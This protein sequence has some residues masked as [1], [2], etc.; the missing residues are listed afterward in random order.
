MVTKAAVNKVIKDLDGF[1]LE[2]MNEHTMA[3]LG[4]GVIY[5]GELVY[6]KGMGLADIEQGKPA[7]P[8]TIFRIGSI[9]KTFITIALMQMWEKGVFKLDDPV[10]D[11]LTSYKLLHD[12]PNAPPVT[13]RHMMTHTAGVGET[14]TI[15]DGIK[16][17]FGKG[18]IGADPDEPV[19]PLSEFYSGR[20][21]PELHP[22]KKWAYA[23]HVYATLGQVI[24]DISGQPFEEYVLE[25]VFEPLGMTHSD[26]L[27]S[28]RVKPEFAQGYMMKKGKMEKV[29]YK[30]IIIGAAGS[31]FSSVNDMAKYAA[32]L[33]N[34]GANEHGRVLKA[35][36]LALMMESHFATDPRVFDIGLTFW[37]E[38]FGKHLVVQHGGGWDGF[39]SMMKV[40]PEAKVG[41]VAF[42]NTS[43]MGTYTVADGI[44][45]R[46]LGVPDPA[47]N[48]PAK[49]IW[50]RPHDWEKLCGHYGPIPGVL[51]NLRFWGM[52]GGEAEV[53]VNKDNQ[54]AV[55]GIFGPARKGLT[56]YRSDPDD[57]L[58]FQGK[59]EIMTDM[60]F[61]AAFGKNEEG[62]VDRL[63]I[64]QYALYKRPYKQSMRYK[65]RQFLGVIAG[66]VLFMVVMKIIKK[67]KSK[68]G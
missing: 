42:T 1:L 32:A 24:E 53:Y 4:V 59:I 19:I 16:T 2:N 49:G 28:E 23:N 10:N 34:G 15:E 33:M 27:L 9:S 56:I 64:Q 62:M 45:Y 47:E 38:R 48:I 17:I 61:T 13:F 65:V 36:T 54:L 14:R 30:R 25:N 26:F 11:Y 40:A 5:D 66:N 3:G 35:E 51:T 20:L 57:P 29:P 67:K 68:K 22:G 63:F 7:T 60:P 8:D 41:V 6:A 39:I 12:D 58:V 55:R 44:L 52:L 43:S 18:E 46:L 31:V 37:R 50:K 21:R